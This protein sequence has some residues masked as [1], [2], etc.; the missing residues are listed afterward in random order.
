MAKTGQIGLDNL[1]IALRENDENIK[2]DTTLKIAGLVTAD[3]EID[4]YSDSLYA[5]DVVADVVNGF[6]EGTVT[7][8]GRL[9]VSAEFSFAITGA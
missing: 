7:V 1:H 3:V 5:D 6:S 8:D 2:A 9:C 4:M